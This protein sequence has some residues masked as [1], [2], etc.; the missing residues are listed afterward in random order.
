MPPTRNP[1]V[2]RVNLNIDPRISN[3][4]EYLLLLYFYNIKYLKII[5]WLFY[6]VKKIQFFYKNNQK[7]V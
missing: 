5:S 4:L 1:L 2:D 3:I 6:L 7:N